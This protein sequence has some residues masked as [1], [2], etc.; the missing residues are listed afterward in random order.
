M[1]LFNRAV[2]FSIDVNLN[3]KLEFQDIFID[4][5]S[6]NTDIDNNLKNFGF[7]EWEGQSIIRAD[8]G[9]YRVTWATRYLGPVRIDPEFREALPYG[10]AFDGNGLTCLGVAAGD[11]DCRPVG[12]ADSYF[13]HDMSFYFYGDVWTIGVGARNVLDEAPPLVD[14]RA[15]FSGWN[16]PFGNGY[17]INGRE[18]FLNVAAHF[19]DIGF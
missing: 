13:R 10:N 18:Y 12:S 6:G 19:D 5:A 15:V 1:D 9:E 8:I 4:S 17:D 16:V 11:V 14:G 2:D 7:P 3:R